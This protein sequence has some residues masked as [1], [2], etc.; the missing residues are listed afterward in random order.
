MT[1]NGYE[2]GLMV[3]PSIETCPCKSSNVLR[4]GRTERK[5]VNDNR[6]SRGNGCNRET[7]NVEASA[8]ADKFR[9]PLRK[10]AWSTFA[11][12]EL[13][14]LRIFSREI[15]K[16]EA[17]TLPL[18]CFLELLILKDFKSFEPEVLILGYFKSLFPEV[19]ILLGFK[20]LLMSK[21]QKIENFPEVLILEVL[22]TT[23]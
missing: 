11:V 14:T 20:R 3:P 17:D 8:T 22:G 13:R 18:P 15:S 9:P 2:L 16:R 1:E 19:L 12:S 10:A 6:N 23:K 4:S 5:R 21:L 7:P